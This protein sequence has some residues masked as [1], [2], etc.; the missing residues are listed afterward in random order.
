MP[1]YIGIDVSKSFVECY[2]PTVDDVYKTS[3][4]TKGFTSLFR[5]LLPS[6]ALRPNT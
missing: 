3:N 6:L 1:N 4:D 2:D 5:S